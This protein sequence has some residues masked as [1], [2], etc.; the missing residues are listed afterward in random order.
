MIGL[1][2]EQP[3]LVHLPLG[4]GGAEGGDHMAEARLMQRDHVH[5]ALDHDQ[6][7]L[8]EGGVPGAGEVED[9]RALVEQPGLRRVEIFR[10]RR[11]IER[12][13]A[14]G[15]DATAR[16]GDRDGEPVAKPVVGAR[17]SS[18]L[19]RRPASSSC[20]FAEILA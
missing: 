16:I 17:P 14:E 15:D 13:G 18:G 20:G 7:G 8:V 1:G 3:E 9:H 2:R 11:G 12:A 5:I 19:T 6:L 4:E 10:L